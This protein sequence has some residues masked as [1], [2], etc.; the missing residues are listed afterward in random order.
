M[1]PPDYSSGLRT[2]TVAVFG[3]VGIVIVGVF[4]LG[5]YVGAR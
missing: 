1:E 5:V 4:A 3:F 2:A